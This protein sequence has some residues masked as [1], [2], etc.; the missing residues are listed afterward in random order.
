[1]EGTADA[2]DAVEDGAEVGIDGGGMRR[3][4]STA[5]CICM[6]CKK[7]K[8]TYPTESN[9]FPVESQVPPSPEVPPALGSSPIPSWP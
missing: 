1:M 8:K 6:R 3:C 4:S 5:I 9:R 7:K 2:L